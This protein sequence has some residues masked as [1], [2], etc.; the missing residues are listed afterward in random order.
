MNLSISGHHLVV[1]P[2]LREYVTSKL[3]RIRHH[4]EQVIDVNVILSVEKLQQLITRGPFHQW[5][6][7]RVLRVADGEIELV[8]RTHEQEDL[9]V[10]QIDQLGDD[11]GPGAVEHL[12]VSAEGAG[13]GAGRVDQDGVERTWR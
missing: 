6:G 8:E 2:A 5:L 10:A 12:R 3:E 4:F 13:G 11:L 1:T 7:L 9:V